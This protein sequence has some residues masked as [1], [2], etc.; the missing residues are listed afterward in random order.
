MS[1]NHPNLRTCAYTKVDGS[2]CGGAAYKDSEYCRHHDNL[3]TSMASQVF[4]LP[5]L[6]DPNSVQVATMQIMNALIAGKVTRA[7]AYALFYGLY[8]AKSNL[9]RTT[10][11]PTPIPA[12]PEDLNVLLERAREEGRAQGHAKGRTQGYREA[13]AEVERAKSR[14][15]AED[16]ESLAAYLIKE[17]KKSDPDYVDPDEDY[18]REKGLL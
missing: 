11:A 18:L 7:D 8:L 5:A 15:G 2:P 4:H 10:L 16:G 6:D 13:Y 1:E 3:K 12:D 14:Q 9:E 17:F